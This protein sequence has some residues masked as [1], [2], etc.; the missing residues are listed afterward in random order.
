MCC[1]RRIGYMMMVSRMS[2]YL[3]FGKRVFET[4]SPPF[5]K[6]FLTQS[7]CL[8]VLQHV[9]TQ[10]SLA[11]CD[12]SCEKTDLEHSSKY[13]Q[14]AIYTTAPPRFIEVIR[15]RQDSTIGQEVCKWTLNVCG[16]LIWH[17]PR[18]L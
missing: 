18:A 12:R 5:F 13:S 17:S 11:L 10:N 2:K 15:L 3:P 14:S 6:T 9:R 4:G 16:S 7:S 8:G 1:Q